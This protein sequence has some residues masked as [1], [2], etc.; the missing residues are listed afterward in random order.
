MHPPVPQVVNL[1]YIPTHVL[2]HVRN[3][4][5]KDR[6]PEVLALLPADNIRGENF[7]NKLLTAKVR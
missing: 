2:V 3:I 1:D 4:N 5:P 6:A 7:N